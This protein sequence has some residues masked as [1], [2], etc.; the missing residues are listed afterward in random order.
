[1]SLYTYQGKLSGLLQEI[2]GNVTLKILF[3]TR[4]ENSVFLHGLQLGSAAEWHW[5][6]KGRIC[7]DTEGVPG[8]AFLL[9]RSPVYCQPM[10]FLLALHK[11]K[12]VTS[13]YE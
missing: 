6:N 13:F 1:M 12:Q 5:C 8:W 4:N 10:H 3:I 9:F 11:R 2:I 7:P